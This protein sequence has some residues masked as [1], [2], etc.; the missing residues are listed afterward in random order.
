MVGAIAVA[1]S[2]MPSTAYAQATG[3]WVSGV[4]D[5]ANPCSRTAPCK[6]F[7]GA[8]SKTAAGGEI[9]V[10]DPGGFGA[11]TITKSI[12][13]DGGGGQVASIIASGVNGIVVNAA[14]TDT[15]TI[16]NVRMN[17]LLPGPNVAGL[18][19][20]QYVGGGTLIVE[21][22]AIYGFSLNGINIIPST[23]NNRVAIIN[24]TLTNNGAGI[25]LAPTGGTVN[26]SATEVR[27]FRN[28]FGIGISPTGAAT[29]ALQM[30]RVTASEN[31]G[32][33]V[34]VS[35]TGGSV[36]LTNSQLSHNGTNGIS[37]TSPGT[38]VSYVTNV[39]AANGVAN[40]VGTLTTLPLG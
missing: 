19:G 4:G 17:G 14:S 39:I 40:V 3:T 30:D 24:T 27:I 38:A 20:I 26:A 32:N 18:N 35:N 23:N 34:Q 15:V 29:A 28:S 13:I 31:T 16:R 37:I 8:I 36:Q 6:T 10:L 2:Q 1:F 33:G 12:T 5:D 25:Q 22:C 11:V 7:A 21:N 9:R